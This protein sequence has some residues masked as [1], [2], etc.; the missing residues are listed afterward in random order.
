MTEPTGPSVVL[1]L[2][3]VVKTYAGT[4]PVRALRGV[5]LQIRSGELVSVVGP[6]GS[7]KSTLLHIMGTLDR[8]SSGRIHVAG[9][10]IASL[11]D[12]QMSALRSRH[13]GFVFQQFFLLSDYTALDNV[14]DG[15][16]YTGIPARKRREMAAAALERVGLGHRL[17]QVS[18]KLSGGERQRVAVARAIVGNPAIVLADE[19]TGNLDTLSSDAIVEL[20]E[21]LN[22]DGVTIVVITHNREIA[23]QMPRRVGIRDGIIDYDTGVAA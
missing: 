23:E 1:S 9:F 13:I 17:D 11:S 3:N 4:P 6:S 2:S 16:L 7:G 21:D 5:D 14:A 20:L 10:D 18:N 8:P 19:P 15:L 22:T 12:R